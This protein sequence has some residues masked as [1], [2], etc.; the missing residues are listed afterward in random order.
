M[1]W[2]EHVN[3][4]NV[5]MVAASGKK[6]LRILKVSTYVWAE[7][8]EQPAHLIFQIKCI[9]LVVTTQVNSGF[10]RSLIGQMDWHIIYELV[11]ALPLIYLFIIII[12]FII[13]IFNITLIYFT[14][15]SQLFFF[16]TESK[17]NWNR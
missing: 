6:E 16:F 10:S 5:W 12:I 3:T 4:G 9:V 15:L 11:E 13:V 14:W 1:E 2:A 8:R 17:F 7:P